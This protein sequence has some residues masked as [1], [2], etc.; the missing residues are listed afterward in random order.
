MIFD[1]VSVRSNFVSLNEHQKQYFHEWRYPRVKIQVFVFMSEIKSDVILTKI[2]FSVYFML[3]ST[4]IKLLPILRRSRQKTNVRK[5]FFF[6]A[7]SRQFCL[8]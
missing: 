4:I 5:Q 6:L 1:F 7:I 2:L 3:L 8:V